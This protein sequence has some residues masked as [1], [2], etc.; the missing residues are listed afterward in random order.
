MTNAEANRILRNEKIWSDEQEQSETE[1]RSKISELEKQFRG[2][3]LEKKEGEKLRGELK[4]VRAELNQHTLIYSSYSDNTAESIAAELRTQFFASECVLYKQ[5]KKKVFKDLEDF[6][7]KIEDKVALDS[8][9]QALIVNFELVL[10]IE[11]PDEIDGRFPEDT[12]L[13]KLEE[14]KEEEKV[15]EV[16]KVAPKRKTRRKK[17]KSS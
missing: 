17:K 14:E 9:R 2:G 11:M 12:W 1:M 3:D 13:D 7:N 15:E 16:E 8:Y 10:G 5:N 6:R 4:D